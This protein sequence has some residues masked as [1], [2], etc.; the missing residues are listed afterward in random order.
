MKIGVFFTFNTSLKKWHEYGMI[1][2]EVA[3]YRQLAE[4]GHEVI[5]FTYGDHSDYDYQEKCGPVRI[6]PMY[7]RLKNPRRSLL[8]Y[9][10]SFTLPF[11]LKEDFVAPDIYKTNQMWGSWVPGLAKFLYKKP[12]IIRCGY[13]Q[14]RFAL[15]M[16]MP[17]SFKIFTYVNALL[18]YWIADVVVI[19]NKIGKEFIKKYFKV[20]GKKIKVQYNYVETDRFKP[21]TQ[22]R[23]SDRILFVGRL[24][25]QKNLFAL[26]DAVRQ[27]PCTLDVVGGGRLKEELISY[28]KKNNIRANL[29]GKV[30][31]SELP[32]VYNRYGVYILPSFCE[33][34]PKTLLE[35]MA[36]GLAVIGSDIEG[37]NNIIRHEVTGYLCRTDEASILEAIRT[38]MTDRALQSSLEQAARTYIEETHSLDAILQQEKEIYANIKSGY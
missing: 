36:C 25:K 17:W 3:L 28:V 21:L 14:F 15:L 35:A 1:D 34:M 10:H 23:A 18:S 30:S 32:K 4:H 7:A 5:F 6:V 22:T 29:L 20:Q 11:R 13:E 31:N 9:L 2:R 38:V 37:I 12:L 33:G 19:S 26:L 27:T 16:N 24:E 8:R